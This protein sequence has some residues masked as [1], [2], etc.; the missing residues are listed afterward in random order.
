MELNE[1]QNLKNIRALGEEKLNILGEILD[2]SL[3]I[4][5]EADKALEEERRGYLIE[6]ESQEESET[7]EA[8]GNITALVDFREE[9]IEK[10]KNIDLSAKHCISQIRGR[11]LGARLELEKF[12]KDFSA[13]MRAV[14]DGIKSADEVS[15][16]RLS[17]LMSGIKAK[18]NA[19]KENR[20]LMNKFVSTNEALSSSGTLL[21]EKK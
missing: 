11:D 21:S 4:K 16:G 10:I 19:V 17:E 9:L 14:L 18:I 6:P 3:K 12:E 5:D 8:I 20:A 15:A 13:D 1:N 2:I 7:D